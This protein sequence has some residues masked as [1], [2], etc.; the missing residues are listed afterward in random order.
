MLKISYEEVWKK[1]ITSDGNRKGTSAV[2]TLCSGRVR[3]A[4]SKKTCAVQE[5]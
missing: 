5:V 3:W 2:V 1:K 4:D